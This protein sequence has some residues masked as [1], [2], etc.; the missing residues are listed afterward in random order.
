MAKKSKPKKKNKN[1]DRVGCACQ[2]STGAT[3]SGSDR[4][5][6]AL[7]KCAIRRPEK[8]ISEF[9]IKPLGRKIDLPAAVEFIQEARDFCP[10]L[11]NSDPVLRRIVRRY[12]DK[13]EVA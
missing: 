11:I 6:R 4:G 8:M 2:P 1:L 10:D 3:R 13:G 9:K 5:Q 7:G 12:V